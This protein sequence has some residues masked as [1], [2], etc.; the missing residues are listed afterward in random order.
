M[1]KREEDRRRALGVLAR[2]VT[3][4]S[5]PVQPL[6]AM[7][8][9]TGDAWGYSWTSQRGS[10]DVWPCRAEILLL[11]LPLLYLG[12]LA[13]CV[14]APERQVLLEW[15]RREHIQELLRRSKAYM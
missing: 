4:A 6:G 3:A 13:M 9:A 8:M 12:F 11:A 1:M 15:L 14:Y 10:A 5:T 2:V 7:D